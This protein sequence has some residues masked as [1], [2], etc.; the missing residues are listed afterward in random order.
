M[1]SPGQGKPWG[2]ITWYFIHTFCERIDDTFFINNRDTVLKILSNVCSMIPCPSC[3]SHA[4]QYL[5]K[6]PMIK[7]VRNKEELKAYFFRFH[8]HATLNGNPSASPADLSVIDMYKRA[9]FKRIAEAFKYE[10][11][12]K[13]PTRLDYSHTLHAQTTLKYI[14]T[15]LYANQRW[16]VA[17]NTHPNTENVVQT[18]TE[19]VVQ[20]NTENVTQTNTENVVQP[21]ESE[22]IT[23]SIIE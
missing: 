10:Y 12:K 14:L 9:N 15:F 22:N 16:F 1:I 8:N 18:N 11:S 19:N 20:T 2:K 13:T 7:I 4:E 23:L 6:N 3:R 21:S 5:K 17:K